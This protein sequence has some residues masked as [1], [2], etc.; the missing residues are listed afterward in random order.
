MVQPTLAA[1]VEAV[2]K[3]LAVVDKMVAL[4][5]QVSSSSSAINK[6]RHE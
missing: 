1:V 2:D 4:E 3:L 6:V 5:A